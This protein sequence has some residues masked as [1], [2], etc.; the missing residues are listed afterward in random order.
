M[1]K[2]K[3]I[4][5]DLKNKLFYSGELLIFGIAFCV[6]G[7]LVF[8]GVIPLNFL[9]NYPLVYYI[10]TCVGSLVGLFFTLRTLLIKDKRKKSGIVDKI[11]IIPSTIFLLIIDISYFFGLK[12]FGDTNINTAVGII[13]I[14][15]SVNYIFQSVYF[16]FIPIPGLINDLTDHLDIRRFR[17]YDKDLY[18]KYIIDKNLNKYLL[19]NKIDNFEDANKDFEEKI[20]D[21]D[22]YAISEIGSKDIIGQIYLKENEDSSATFE[23][24]IIS[25]KQ[26]LGYALEASKFI[27]NEAFKSKISNIKASVSAKNEAGIN[28]LNKLGFTKINED[29]DIIYFEKLEK[30]PESIKSK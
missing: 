21:T 7:I 27:I 19:L 11:L 13:F 15:N 26:R 12:I 6:L 16:F 10:G 17:D 29:N 2:K 24:I 18:C 23:I 4:T 8:T 9:N 25:E 5:E 14:Y 30:M 20:Y 1:E 3:R 28:L 22:Y